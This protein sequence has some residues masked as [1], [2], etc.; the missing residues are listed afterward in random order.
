MKKFKDILAEESQKGLISKLKKMKVRW[1]NDRANPKLRLE[2]S[3]ALQ[4]LDWKALSPKDKDTM[5][6]IESAI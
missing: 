1:D 5:E 2:I 4:R 3:K 6:R